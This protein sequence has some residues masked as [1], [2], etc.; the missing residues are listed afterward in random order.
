MNLRTY[1]RLNTLAAALLRAELN[2][3]VDAAALRRHEREELRSLAA[4]EGADFRIVE[5]VAPEPVLRERIARR[6][7]DDRDPSDATPE[8]LDLQLRVREPVGPEEAALVLDTDADPATV[9]RRCET[10]GSRL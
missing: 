10:L 7:A 3:I 9:M 8:V 1:A 6:M 4:A 5:C 2:V